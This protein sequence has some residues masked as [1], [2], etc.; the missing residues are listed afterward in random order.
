M[1]YTT[2]IIKKY[3]RKNIAERRV[4]R[5]IKFTLSFYYSSLNPITEIKF[6]TISPS[7]LR[8]FI[9]CIQ[10]EGKRE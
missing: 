10:C 4:L 3:E 9:S 6:S 5:L 7:Q 1:Y 2:R 8:A